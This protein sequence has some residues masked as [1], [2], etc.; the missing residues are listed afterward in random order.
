MKSGEKHH[1]KREVHPNM[2]LIKP[3]EITGRFH[4][5]MIAAC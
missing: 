1:G 3:G 5:A 4:Y 2:K